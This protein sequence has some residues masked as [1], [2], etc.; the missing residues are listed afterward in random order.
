MMLMAAISAV[1]VGSVAFYLRFLF[2]L[3][4]ESRTHWISYLVRLEPESENEEIAIYE[5]PAA[6]DSLRRA[7]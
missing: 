2:A 5:E 6:S 3:W 4:K 1:C 7:A